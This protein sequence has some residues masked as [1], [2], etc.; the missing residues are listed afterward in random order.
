MEKGKT[1][2]EFR[3][4]W[5]CYAALNRCLLADMTTFMPRNDGFNQIAPLRA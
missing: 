3:R 5:R 1:R 4:L 2:T